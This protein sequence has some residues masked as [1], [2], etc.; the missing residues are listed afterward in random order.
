MHI[1]KCVGVDVIECTKIYYDLAVRTP[2]CLPAQ[3]I[4]ITVIHVSNL[5]KDIYQ[6]EFIVALAIIPVLSNNTCEQYM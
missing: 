1:E 5:T 6:D 4:C 3:K 2:A